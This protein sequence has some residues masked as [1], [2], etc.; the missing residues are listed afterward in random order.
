[1]LRWLYTPAVP[2]SNLACMSWSR[3]TKQQCVDRCNAKYEPLS[4]DWTSKTCWEACLSLCACDGSTMAAYLR[5][6]DTSCSKLGTCGLCPLSDIEAVT[7]L[8]VSRRKE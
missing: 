8:T 5:E 7:T 6:I 3:Q 2:Y 4:S 1:M